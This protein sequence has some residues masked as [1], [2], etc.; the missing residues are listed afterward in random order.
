MLATGLLGLLLACLIVC[1]LG[2]GS[3]VVKQQPLG[4]VVIPGLGRAD[5]LLTVVHNIQA[6]KLHP[7]STGKVNDWD[8]MIYIYA[9]RADE[10]FWRHSK[11]LG[12]LARYCQLIDSPNKKVTEN[13]HRL[14]PV[15][16]QAVYKYV[17]LLL[18]D[19]KVNKDKPLV[20][21][22]AVRLMECNN[23]TVLSPVISGANKGGGQRFRDIMQIAAP[24]HTAGHVSSFVEI[25]AWMMTMPAYTALWELLCPT[26]NPYAWGYDFWY[27]GYARGTVRG[28]RMGITNAFTLQHEQDVSSTGLGRTD[29]TAVEVKWKAVEAQE[30]Y[31]RKH[32]SI[33]LRQ[34]RSQLDISN[35]S[36]NGPVKGY[37][38]YCKS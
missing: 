14:Q 12:F 28:H 16:I 22:Q 17:F 30:R 7:I 25:F 4:L 9:D 23:L 29:N 11:E 31:Y 37:M 15:D 19:C 38:Q 1:M 2:D 26:V 24:P 34:F 13:L 32:R 18:D 20:L 33:P 6:L 5:R 3:T 36:W 10:Q 8:C 35:T 21:A 27:N